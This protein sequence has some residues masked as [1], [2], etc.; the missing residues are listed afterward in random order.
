[1][2][3]RKRREGKRVDVDTETKGIDE[4]QCPRSACRE[5]P[6]PREGVESKEPAGFVGSQTKVRRDK[7]EN[8]V[9]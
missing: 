7:Q 2:T 8:A 3:A 5:H 4:F 1:M 9:P 6:I